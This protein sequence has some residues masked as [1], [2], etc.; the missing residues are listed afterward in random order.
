M[1]PFYT[2]LLESF[3]GLKSQLIFGITLGL[4]LLVA[5]IFLSIGFDDKGMTFFFGLTG[6]EDESLAQNGLARAFVYKELFSV[7]IAGVW[8]TWIAI[9][10]ALISCAPIFPNTMTEGGAG[11]VMTKGVSRLQIFAAKFVGSLF[12]VLIQV[13]LF[14]LIVFVAFKWRLGSWH[15]QL[16]WYVPAVLL[17]FVS[18]YSFLVLVAVK[19]RS[20]LTALLLTF[21]VWGISALLG[22]SEEKMRAFMVMKERGFFAQAQSERVGSDEESLE[23]STDGPEAPEEEEETQ[24]VNAFEENDDGTLE[25]VHGVVKTIHSFFPKNGPIMDEAKKRLLLEEVDHLVA[26]GGDDVEE[27][28]MRK[29]LIDHGNSSFYTIWSSVLF[30]AVML[31]LAAFSFCRRDY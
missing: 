29:D 18:L 13:G 8:L 20:V 14:V 25:R 17:V 7:G 23:P 6:F 24:S 22:F 12:F 10:L 11:M 28:A 5:F 1:K 30:A 31:A 15:P 3:R 26:R 4:S 2:L 9:I 16:F 19:T 21:L 27:M